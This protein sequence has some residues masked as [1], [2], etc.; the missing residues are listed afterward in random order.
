VAYTDPEVA[1]V[2]VTETE[3][4]EAGVKYGKGNFPWAASGRSL[5][6][7]RDEGMTKVIF[8][9][10]M[11]LD[12]FVKASNAT[13]EQPL[14]ESGE[15]LHQWAFSEDER[16]RARD[17]AAWLLG[18]AANSRGYR[19]EE[20]V[21]RLVQVAAEM[22]LPV[23]AALLA[24]ADGY[25]PR[26]NGAL[27]HAREELGTTAE[28]AN[29]LADNLPAPKAHPGRSRRR[30][31]RKRAKQQAQA[32]QSQQGQEQ[33]E[34]DTNVESLPAPA[35]EEKQAEPEPARAAEG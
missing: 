34:Q 12:G 19:H 28:I 11:S 30:R 17:Y 24:S 4:K 6:L 29:A 13:P 8:D 26:A 33:T 15:R 18:A 21:N 14:G 7:G 5:S 10:S 31:R 16:D 3:A 20:N 22:P 9:M 1:W 23:G 32:A 35:S 27:D 25:T 2:G